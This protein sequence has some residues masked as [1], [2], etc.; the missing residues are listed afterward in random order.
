VL[1]LIGGLL[2]IPGVTDWLEKFLEP[3]FADS[4]NYLNIPGTGTEWL[5][6]ALGGLIAIVGIGIAYLFYVRRPG[7]TLRLR[8]RFRPVYDFLSHKWY[9]DEAYDALFVRPIA[10]FGTWSQSVVESR[11]VQGF[12]VGGAVGV[13]RAGSG[14]ARALQTGYVRAYALLLVFGVVCLGL[15]FL[16]QSS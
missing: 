16:V 10:S 9:F 3:S 4:K 13:V 12:I 8:E 14:V 1:S 15:Y 5:G 6:L 11:F 2:L 7:T